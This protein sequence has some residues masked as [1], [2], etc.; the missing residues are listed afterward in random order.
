MTIRLGSIDMAQAIDSPIVNNPYLL[1]GVITAST[2]YNYVV[3]YHR[4]LPL[5]TQM[6]GQLKL[7]TLWLST[8]PPPSEQAMNPQ[9]SNATLCS[10]I[11]SRGEIFRADRQG[12]ECGQ[13]RA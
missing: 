4:T 11:T 3:V 2:I 9:K 8:S 12:E 13:E 7:I 10:L 5:P 6:E 1:S